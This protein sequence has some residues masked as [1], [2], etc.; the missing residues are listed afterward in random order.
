MPH[1]NTPTPHRFCDY[2]GAKLP[3]AERAKL[4]R[5]PLRCP[6]CQHTRYLNP[7]PSVIAWA[8]RGDTLL[9]AQRA[10]KPKQGAWGLPGGF[11]DYGERPEEAL[12]REMREELGVTIQVNKLIALIPHYYDGQQNEVYNVLGL[13]YE[14][15]FPNEPLRPNDDTAAARWVKRAEVPKPIAFE[16]IEKMIA[17]WQRTGQPPCGA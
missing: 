14:V 16:E 11:I 5:G 6:K 2:C 12:V 10:F 3:K 13:L 9:L 8:T 15:T 17:R 1:T 4:P 7:V